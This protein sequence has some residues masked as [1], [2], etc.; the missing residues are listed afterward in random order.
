MTAKIVDVE[1]AF[2]YGKLEEEIFM[3][4]PPGLKAGSKDK[5]LLLNQYI[6]GLVKA[7]RQ[8]Y[9]HIVDIFKKTVFKG[10]YVD[11][12]LFSKNSELGICFIVVY[13]HDNLIIGAVDETIEPLRKHN[14]VLKDEDDLHEIILAQPF[15]P[16]RM[17]HWSSGTCAREAILALQ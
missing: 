4:C 8:Y 14:L 10:G 2:L 5:V 6:Y 15:V 9:K 1:I 13:V 16:V 17:Q 12:C 3:E 7:A 11:P